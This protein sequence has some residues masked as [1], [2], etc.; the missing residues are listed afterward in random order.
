DA[1]SD[2]YTYVWKTEKSWAGACRQLIVR[3]NDGS[4]R[5]AYFKF[6]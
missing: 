2:Q 6:K 4:E 3:L 5:V 1:A